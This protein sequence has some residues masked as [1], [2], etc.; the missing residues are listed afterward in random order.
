MKQRYQESIC[1]DL[2]F[3]LNISKF[4]D[5]SFLARYS[6][7]YRVFVVIGTAVIFRR[8]RSCNPRS[9]TFYIVQV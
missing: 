5:L 7:I 8:L 9:L 3:K 1:I 6:M 4:T 2:A